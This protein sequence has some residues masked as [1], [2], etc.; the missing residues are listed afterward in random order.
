MPFLEAE[1]GRHRGNP[2]HG[3]D[4]ATGT[5]S[6]AGAGKNNGFDRFIFAEF[7]VSPE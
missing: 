5:E 1:P 4:V 3:P 2:L 6:F 7:F